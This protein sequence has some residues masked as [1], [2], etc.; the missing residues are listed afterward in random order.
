[1]PLRAPKSQQVWIRIASTYPFAFIRVLPMPIDADFT[2]RETEKQVILTI[3]L[4][5]SSPKSVDVFGAS[6]P[7]SV[8]ARP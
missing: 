4:K 5:G 1:M 8:S 3:P 6:L 7:N 2:W